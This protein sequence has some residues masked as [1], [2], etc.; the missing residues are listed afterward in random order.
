MLQHPPNGLSRIAVTPMLAGQHICNPSGPLRDDG[1]L[2]VAKWRLT[3]LAYHPIEPNLASVR[4]LTC[5][6]LGINVAYVLERGRWRIVEVAIERP[7]AENLEH[8]LRMVHGQ[9]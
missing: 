9:R 6:E 1:S 3:V 4:R 5:F 8:R 7:L 2:Y